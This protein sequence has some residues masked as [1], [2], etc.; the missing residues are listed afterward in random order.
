MAEEAGTTEVKEQ[1]KTEVIPRSP[2]ELNIDMVADEHGKVTTD[3]GGLFSDEAKPSEEELSG[4]AKEAE[5]PSEKKEEAKAEPAPTPKAEGEK[6]KEQPKKEAKE[7]VEKKPKEEPKKE[8]P[9]EG[10]VPKEALAQA[11]SQVRVLKDELAKV[12]AEIQEKP[13]VQQRIPQDDKWKDFKVLSDAEYDQMVDDDPIEAQKYTRKLMQYERYQEQQERAKAQVQQSKAHFQSLVDQSVKSIEEAVPGIYEEDSDVASQLATFA[14]EH[15]FSDDNYLDAMT[16]PA[17]LIIPPGHDKSYVLG[18]GAASLIKLLNNLRAK[19][20]DASDPAKLREEI[21][22]EIEPKLRE[23]ITKELVAKF[24]GAGT[25]KF[26]SLTEVPGSGDKP[27]ASGKALTEAEW[28][29]LS[30]EEREK[31]LQAT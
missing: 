22:K 31:Y 28:A 6:P 19:T 27:D 2:T 12:K 16:N 17:T 8:K 3:F 29:K 10:F 14:V 7:E 21:Q 15:G 9:P 20:K 4:E 24:K 18:P 23:E 5:K 30:D 11:R 13:A 1:A 26:K 25:D